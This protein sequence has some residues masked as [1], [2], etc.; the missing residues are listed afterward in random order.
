VTSAGTT[1]AGTEGTQA[2]ELRTA[3]YRGLHTAR[4]LRA[5]DL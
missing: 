4:G 2:I 1:L 5:D 3:V